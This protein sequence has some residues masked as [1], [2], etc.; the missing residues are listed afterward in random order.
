[1]GWPGQAVEDHEE[2]V[3]IDTLLPLFGGNAEGCVACVSERDLHPAYGDRHPDALE[4]RPVCRIDRQMGEPRLARN[5]MAVEELLEPSG[6]N[7]YRR[8][9]SQFHA[10]PWWPLVV[11]DDPGGESRSDY[12]IDEGG[13]RRP[14][15]P[16]ALVPRQ[17]VLPDDPPGPDLAPL[18]A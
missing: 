16:A 6:G 9:G 10:R 18:A 15:E 12:R 8:S 14:A 2:G 7:G 4:A 17:R 11:S 3:R 1:V 5:A 13:A